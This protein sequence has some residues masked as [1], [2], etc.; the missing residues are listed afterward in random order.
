MNTD[1]DWVLHKARNALNAARFS[2]RGRAE[3]PQQWEGVEGD[4]YRAF[5]ELYEAAERA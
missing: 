3:D 1:L 2:D 4:L 5:K